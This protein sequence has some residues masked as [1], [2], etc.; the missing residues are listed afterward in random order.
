MFN[1]LFSD[2]YSNI[3]PHIWMPK[4]SDTD[5]PSARTI[6]KIYKK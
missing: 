5:D 3:I 2:K 4:W 6:K 1:K